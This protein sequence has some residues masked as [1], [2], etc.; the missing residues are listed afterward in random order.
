MKIQL[1]EKVVLSPDNAW[2]LAEKLDKTQSIPADLIF[3]TCLRH[4]N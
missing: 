2:F 1:K 3:E 4:S